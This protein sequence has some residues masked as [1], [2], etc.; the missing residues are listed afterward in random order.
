MTITSWVEYFIPGSF[1][2]ETEEKQLT[3][4]SLTEAMASIPRNAYG[5]RLYEVVELSGILENGETIVQKKR[6]NESGMYYPGA[7]VYTQDTVPNIGFVQDNMRGNRWAHVV[8]TRK[9]TWQPFYADV[10]RIVAE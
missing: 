10:D 9:G 3:T 8:K 4:G 7:T 1:F 2:S 5:F 6:Q